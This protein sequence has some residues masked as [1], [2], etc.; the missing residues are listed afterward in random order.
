MNQNVCEDEFLKSII[1]IL[2]IPNQFLHS[3]SLIK[4]E[5]LIDWLCGEFSLTDE[6]AHSLAGDLVE[7][8]MLKAVSKSLSRRKRTQTTDALDELKM[9][10]IT[11]PRK[12]SVGVI[13]NNV[14]KFVLKEDEEFVSPIPN[15]FGLDFNYVLSIQ[16]Y[17][18]S[19]N[20]KFIQEMQTNFG[21]N[22]LVHNQ[23]E[24]TLNIYKL[25]PKD[26]QKETKLLFLLLRTIR[27]IKKHPN[28]LPPR[29]L[30]QNDKYFIVDVVILSKFPEK[31]EISKK[32]QIESPKEEL[33][34]EN[35][36][37]FL[38]KQKQYT[39]INVIN[40][41]RQVTDAITHLH[42]LDYVSN[43]INLQNIFIMKLLRKK[44]SQPM[45]RKDSSVYV[46]QASF[47]KPELE[48][49]VTVAAL[50][51]SNRGNDLSRK[52]SLSKTI[53]TN[54]NNNINNSK[55]SLDKSQDVNGEQS[56][57]SNK[58]EIDENN[59][60]DNN[61]NN[62]NNN[63]NNNNFEIKLSDNQNKKKGGESNLKKQISI[64]RNRSSTDRSDK[65][66]SSIT[67]EEDIEQEEEDEDNYFFIQHERY[68]VVLLLIEHTRPEQYI[69]NVQK[70]LYSAPEI[71]YQLMSNINDLQN[72]E[73]KQMMLNF[74]NSASD[75]WS[76]GICLYMLVQGLRFP[77]SAS[78]FQS[79]LKLYENF[80]LNITLPGR[81]KISK[82]IRL[83]LLKILRDNPVERISSTDLLQLLKDIKDDRL[84]VSEI[85]IN[86]NYQNLIY[87]NSIPLN[88]PDSIVKEASKD[89][90]K[91]RSITQ[92]KSSHDE[93]PI[94][95]IL[96][97]AAEIPSLSMFYEVIRRQS[98][99]PLNCN[100]FFTEFSSLKLNNYFL[101]VIR[102]IDSLVYPYYLSNVDI[103]CYII[104]VEK[105]EFTKNEDQI[106]GFESHFNGFKNIYQS[107]NFGI[108]NQSEHIDKDGKVIY[109][110]QSTVQYI[111]VLLN[112]YKF[113]DYILKLQETDEESV[114]DAFEEEKIDNESVQKYL[115]KSIFEA[116]NLNEDINQVKLFCHYDNNNNHD[117]S[118]EHFIN[119]ME[120]SNM[121][122]SS[123]N[124]KIS[125]LKTKKLKLLKIKKTKS[126]VEGIKI[127]INESKPHTLNLSYTQLTLKELDEIM[128]LIV[129][130]SSLL[131][132]NLSGNNIG[133]NGISILMNGLLQ[134]KKSI[135]NLI[136]SDCSITSNGV[137]T[138]AHAISN[139]KKLVHIDLSN[140]AIS[141]EG[142]IRMGEF[143]LQ[144]ATLTTLN[145]FNC[146]FSSAGAYSILRAV[147]IHPKIEYLNIASNPIPY[148]IMRLISYFMSKN[149]SP[150]L[151][152]LVTNDLLSQVFILEYPYIKNNEIRKFLLSK[153][154]GASTFSSVKLI[155]ALADQFS[156]ATVQQ[157]HLPQFGLQSFKIPR[158][159]RV[160]V[161]N[162]TIKEK[163]IFERCR[164]VN[165]EFNQLKIVPK[166]GSFIVLTVLNLSF[167]KLTMIGGALSILSPLLEELYLSHNLLS[168]SVDIEHSL[169]GFVKLRVLDLRHNLLTSCFNIDDLPALSELMLDN[170]Q[171]FQFPSI[172][173]SS[174]NEMHLKK[175]ANISLSG[176]PA[177][178]RSI[179]EIFHSFSRELQ[180]L[181]LSNCCISELSRYIG[182]CVC[183]IELNLSQNNIKFLPPQLGNL[184]CLK[185]LNLSNNRL[186]KYHSIYPIIHL[187]LHI[188]NLEGNPLPS[189]LF[190]IPFQ[191][192]KEIIESNVPKTTILNQ[193]NLSIIGPTG[194]GKS[195]LARLLPYSSNTK[196]LK[197]KIHSKE[198]IEP[199]AD[200]INLSN[201]KVQLDPE[202]YPIQNVYNNQSLRFLIWDFK[203]N[204]IYYQ[205]HALFLKER[206]VFLVLINLA[207]PE[208]KQR[209][210]VNQWLN[211]IS[212]SPVILVGTQTDVVKENFI[213]T[214][215]H[216][217]ADSYIDYLSKSIVDYYGRRCSNI[218]NYITISTK[219]YNSIEELGNVIINIAKTQNYL[220]KVY[221]YGYIVLEKLLKTE[222]I[223]NTPP[224][225]DVEQFE[226]IVLSCRIEG[227]IQTVTELTTLLGLVYYSN[228]ISSV[229]ID[230]SWFI[231]L[232]SNI[233][234]D[235]K[236][237]L[238]Q[239][240]YL[241]HTDLP[242]ILL[243]FP[244][245]L[246]PL[247][248]ALFSY[249]E[250]LYNSPIIDPEKNT[251]YSIVPSLLDA[252]RHNLLDS[253]WISVDEYIQ[254]KPDHIQ[255][256]R[257]YQFSST[258]QFGFFFR[259]M[260]RLLHFTTPI[261]M[262][263]HGLL[264][265]KGESFSLIEFQLGIYFYYPN[266]SH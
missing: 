109:S 202:D 130:N 224:V 148:H 150:K 67:I 48:K 86:S 42:K 93:V 140:N 183:L 174:S 233:V 185:I 207:Q 50:D 217:T 107:K 9:P 29:K 82:T 64:L 124:N 248:I 153:F 75:V 165:L 119:L 188:C 47:V 252:Q 162:L 37:N 254:V 97:F 214:S 186:K 40:I 118:F 23:I 94:Y 204:E 32:T 84:F 155:N 135:S 223:L 203:G 16:Q 247:F 43:N 164:V 27:E 144:N 167:N 41:I 138:I 74:N 147:K 236:D 15:Q 128:P 18:N 176:N 240:G 87:E 198:E 156:P 113:T 244:T 149:S 166:L 72:D 54:N 215:E 96:S 134:R 24:N 256:E 110:Q 210:V 35:L 131:T 262:W 25:I 59:K 222:R 191:K 133:D 143:L 123:G 190:N 34:V 171:L 189:I 81:P 158:L 163:V 228:S 112:L 213:S 230:T 58:I 201:W 172:K 63:D 264:C 220:K 55:K 152:S 80:H 181:N 22:F 102:D 3:D 90:L 137:F 44:R 57:D 1:P 104:D 33:L 194:A 4:G 28:L 115:K 132:I 101:P 66:Y 266:L 197:K 129:S 88:T 234:N 243:N 257:L 38:I 238:I 221:S 179:V 139:F 259:L 255:L 168:D 7:N 209:F 2:R 12:S 117:V 120:S 208:A 200:S 116:I 20:I 239:K 56:N 141:E 89:K 49:R 52:R 151:K 249:L 178:A 205:T 105:V 225:I 180:V 73:K 21:R 159:E 242:K 65:I 26:D 76:I 53:R 31:K 160:Y 231:S 260:V 193:I 258:P 227:S 95:N 85:S 175:L 19:D 100:P 121:L 69:H 99:N 157:I 6:K 14:D 182:L 78:R 184:I 199:S 68:R 192:V 122:T 251:H 229:C 13:P 77:I 196:L 46:K 173:L 226:Q 51:R 241:Y 103:I 8:G 136:L 92:R 91:P 142:A 211:M 161:N 195:S 125:V 61:N 145:L 237:N 187:S 169:K 218:T 71:L 108:A 17:D 79:I 60:K 70:N 45:V 212:N 263:K 219:N 154:K 106:F 216:N 30:L 62:N 246:Y 261:L 253:N 206:S 126:A 39:E 235:K 177:I 250:V 36:S 11:T 111:I 146:K 5:H 114:E 232:I 83:F 127:Y 170:N 98:N 245:S 265:K 10:N